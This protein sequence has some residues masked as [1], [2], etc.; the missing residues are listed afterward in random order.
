MYALQGGTDQRPTTSADNNGTLLLKR[1]CYLPYVCL[2]AH[3]LPQHLVIAALM[4]Q[5]RLAHVKPIECILGGRR[6]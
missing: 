4:L 1:N 2:P 3:T 6:A 5:N